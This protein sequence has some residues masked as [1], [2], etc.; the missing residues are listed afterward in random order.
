[1]PSSVDSG[2]IVAPGQRLGHADEYRA[3]PGTYVRGGR[4]YA[5]LVG[6]KQVVPAEGD[7]VR[8]LDGRGGIYKPLTLGF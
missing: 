8:C 7:E 3:G 1:M 2:R 6:E 5:T 4:L